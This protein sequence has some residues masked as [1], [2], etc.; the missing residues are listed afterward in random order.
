MDIKVRSEQLRDYE[1]IDLVISSAFNRYN[2]V[3]LVHDLRET[4]QYKPELSLVATLNGQIIGHI[5]FYP[6]KTSDY[7]TLLL[8]PL[9]VKPE[10]Q[11]K[12]IGG[13]L[14][15]EGLKQ[16]GERGYGSV[17]VVGHPDYY[18]RFGFEKAS[19]WDI[20]LSTNVPDEAFMAIELRENS[21]L[22]KEG[23]VELPQPY[24]EC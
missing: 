11:R 16:S 18:P 23:V 1:E 7:E 14:I 12:G 21:L 13:K 19:I 3:K 15:E 22:G 24:L 9:A 5:L 8:A 6:I 2:E 17:L 20:R 4:K 10:Y